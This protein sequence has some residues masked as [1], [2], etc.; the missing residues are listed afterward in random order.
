MA[1][2]LSPNA[3]WYLPGLLM[4]QV[5][6][7]A[8]FLL[9]CDSLSVGFGS[10]PHFRQPILVCGLVAFAGTIEL[11]VVFV[12]RIRAKRRVTVACHGW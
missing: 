8:L 7:P 5:T 1:D 4:T 12:L 9:A 11:V 6:L 3:W 10:E 2:D